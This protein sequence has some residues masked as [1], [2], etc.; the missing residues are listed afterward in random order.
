MSTLP[1]PA[2]RL[3]GTVPT[4]VLVQDIGSLAE[5]LAQRVKRAKQEDSEAEED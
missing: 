3:A 2:L 1:M 5:A 4:Q